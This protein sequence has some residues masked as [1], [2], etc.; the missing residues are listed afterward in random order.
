MPTDNGGME[1]RR[2]APPALAGSALV[3][4]AL[5]AGCGPQ[6]PA[7]PVDTGTPS[8]T[9]TT[10]APEPTPTPTPSPTETAGTPAAPIGVGCDALLPLQAVY[11]LNPNL[12]VVPDGAPPAGTVAAALVD[13]LGVACDLVHNSNGEI[14]RV[15]AATPG[16]EALAT[17]RAGAVT[18]YDLGTTGI[19]AFSTDGAILAFRGDLVLSAETGGYFGPEELAAALLIAI[20]AIP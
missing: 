10:P 9:A 20:D 12:S 2:L 7:G 19:E 13:G 16:S 8:P 18:G 5:L 3:L 15:A 14:L 6:S 1:R 4:A 17:L 11:D